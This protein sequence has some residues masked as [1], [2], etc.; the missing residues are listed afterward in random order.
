MNRACPV[1]QDQRQMIKHARN[2]AR[3]IKR[4]NSDKR[5][6]EDCPINR[7]CA[8]AEML[9]ATIHLALVEVNSQ[10]D[11]LKER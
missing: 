6:C 10:W 2:L 9:N 7:G 1:I 4:L 8:T 3:A 5:L 11:I